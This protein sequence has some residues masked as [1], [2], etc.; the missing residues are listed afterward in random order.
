M[1]DDPLGVGPV[2]ASRVNEALT[3]SKSE[4]P[5]GR[6]VELVIVGVGAETP[7]EDV[8][9]IVAAVVQPGPKQRAVHRDPEQDV[10]VDIV[11]SEDAPGACVVVWEL[12]L[13]DVGGIRP[14]GL[15]SVIDV[16]VG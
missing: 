2:L 16:L 11:C 4:Q 10:D 14:D 3:Q 13:A 6:G 15:G 1:V 12:E 8:T 9:D 7:A 5:K